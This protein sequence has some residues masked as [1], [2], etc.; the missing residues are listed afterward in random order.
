MENKDM[1]PPPKP[2]K[3]KTAKQ[4]YPHATPPTPT[5]DTTAS[6]RTTMWVL[7]LVAGEPPKHEIIDLTSYSEHVSKGNDGDGAAQGK[8]SKEK[9]PT[10][11]G[12]VN[13]H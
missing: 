7:A 11:A 1:G 3:T 9:G 5:F 8:D 12:E 4:T 10:T 13:R 6:P 2:K